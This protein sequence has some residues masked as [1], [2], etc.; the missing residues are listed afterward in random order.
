MQ[1]ASPL[2][3]LDRFTAG[4]R[5]YGLIAA[6]L[7]LA[8]LPG[9]F[10]LQPLDRDESRFAQATSQMFETGDFVRISF[11]DEP[12][13]KKPVGI[14]WLQ[15]VSVAAAGGPE[16]RAIWAFR[17]PSLAGALLAAFATFWIGARLFN[18]RVGLV[19]G[20]ALALSVLLSTE[21]NIA[22]TDAMLCGAIALAFAGLAGRPSSSGPVWAPQS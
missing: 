3:F 1:A 5:P 10:A 13:H 19:A 6:L 20:G 8:A 2:A 14:H 18:R 7:Y 9:I 16:A 12:R 22:K 17:L 4:W 15:A 11:Q 21:A